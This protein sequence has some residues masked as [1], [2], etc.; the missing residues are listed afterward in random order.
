MTQDSR[1]ADDP[2]DGRP[3]VRLEAT[4]H[5]GDQRSGLEAVADLDLDR[6][7][8]PDAGVRA[9]LAP[10]EA[11]A[12]VRRGYEVRLLRAHPISPL[13][14]AHVTN[15]QDVREWAEQQTRGIERE[16]DA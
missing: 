13:D 4:V 2:A 8:D 9:L 14:P 10:D 12:L 3:D 11:I 7:P 6:I 15:D 16:E 1:R 5:P